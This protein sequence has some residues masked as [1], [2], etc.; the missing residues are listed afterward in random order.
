MFAGPSGTKL[1]GLAN[2]SDDPVEPLIAT[3]EHTEG[4]QARVCTLFLRNNAAGKLEVVQRV[5][6]H[7]NRSDRVTF[8]R[9]PAGNLFC[10]V[11]GSDSLYELCRSRDSSHSPYEDVP[12]E[13][14]LPANARYMCGLHSIGECRIAASLEDNTL[15]VFRIAGGSLSELQRVPLPQVNWEPNSL[16]ALPGGS[17]IVRS[18]FSDLV[19]KKGK[20]GIECCA[21]RPDGTL[22]A[23]KLLLAQEV[24]L[25]FWGLLPPTDAF[26]T[27]RLAA[28]NLNRELCLYPIQP[29]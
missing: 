2:A 15:R 29:Q 3:T 16:V 20:Q 28:F 9:W 25:N 24:L 17:L 13:H 5:V 7:E 8:A 22:A 1:L 6:L 21:A 14:R 10:A 26:P 12:Q 4:P 11:L 19:D 27:Y 23:P 18:W